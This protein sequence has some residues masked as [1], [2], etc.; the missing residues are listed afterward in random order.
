[1]RQL[2]SLTE[3]E[4]QHLHLFVHR[5]KAN[6]RTLTRAR[7]LLKVD[8]RWKDQDIVAAFDI[9][10]ATVTNVCKRY[11]EGGL[12]AVLH[13]K[14]Q[15]HRRSALSGLQTAHLIA[16]AC[17]PSP[18]GHDHWTVR[19]LAQ[20]AVEL[21]FVKSI[22]PNTI[23]ELLKKTNSSPGSTSTGAYHQSEGRRVA[24]MEDVLDLYEEEYDPHYPTVCLDEKPVVLHADVQPPVPVES[25][26]PER[27]DYEYERRGTRNLFVMVEPLAGWRHVEV[28]AQRTMQD[29]AKVVRWL[30]DSVYPHAEYV[31]LVQDNLNT[32]TPASLYETFPPAEARRILQRV[33]FH[34]TPKHGSWLNMAEID[35]A[36]LE[37]NALSR[38]LPDEAALRRQVLAV[39]TERNTQRRGIT[40]QFSSRDARRK[41]ERLYPVKEP[42]AD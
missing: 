40:W 25:G 9:C 11:T 31:R 12:E 21:G 16:V 18:D 17:S 28:T 26:Q 35:I 39:E 5:G 3:E 27:V 36:I 10:Q 2:V 15:Q 41:L 38:R 1:M 8:E 42:V 33:E 30:V 13:D 24:A 23:H 20:K 19:L 22:S 37:R 32:H 6:A 4:R 7:V 34:Y 29:Y 14:V